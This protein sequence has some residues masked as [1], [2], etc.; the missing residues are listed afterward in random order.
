MNLNTSKHPQSNPPAPSDE[1][2][3]IERRAALTV[4]V[5]SFGGWAKGSTYRSHAADAADALEDAGESV[6]ADWFYTVS[7]KTY[8]F[9][10]STYEALLTSC[11]STPCSLPNPS[12]F[13]LCFSTPLPCRLAMTAP[14]A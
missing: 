8:N 2:V 1:T 12:F 9:C 10:M 14:S 11:L 13:N 7:S 4:Y 6:A 5:A 3:F